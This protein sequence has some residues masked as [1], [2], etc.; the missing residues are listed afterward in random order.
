MRIAPHR[1]AERLVADVFNMAG[2]MV[3]ETGCKLEHV[4]TKAV[5]ENICTLLG[6]PDAC[7]HGSPIPQGECCQDATRNPRKLVMP[8]SECQAGESGKVAYVRAKN[9]SVL[10][11]L[12]AMGVLPGLTI[13]TLARTPSFLMQLGESQFAIDSKLASHIYIRLC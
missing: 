9:S 1:L 6:H 12:T 11:K 3:H 13:R 4:L 7:P 8:L 10:N 2:D 5:E